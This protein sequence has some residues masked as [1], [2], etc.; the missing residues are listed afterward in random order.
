MKHSR[1]DDFQAIATGTLLIALAV[2]LFRHG[3]LLTGGTPGLTFLVHYASGWSFGLLYFV[4][5][6]PFYVFAYRVLG[7]GFTLKTFAAVAL[8]SA[9]AELLPLVLRFDWVQPVFAAVLGGLLA[10]S[11]LLMLIR[12]RASLGGLGVLAIW[13][14]DRKGWPVG[15][16][17][18]ACDVAILGGA[19]FIVPPTAVLVSVIG[20]LSLNF[21]LAVNHKPGRYDGY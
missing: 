7:A 20:A 4:L 14:Q 21:V 11:G 6:L 5:N 18:M 9:Y 17:Q 12:H 8:L 2:D 1:F 3:G 19:L 15:K 13:L 10:G 16:V